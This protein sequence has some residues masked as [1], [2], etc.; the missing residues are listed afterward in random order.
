MRSLNSLLRVRAAGG[1]RAEPEG[2]AEPPKAPP[3]PVVRGKFLHVGLRKLYIKGVTYGALTPDADGREYHDQEQIERDFGLMSAA[4]INTVRIPHTMPPRSLLDA[5]QRHGLYVMVGLS[6]EQFVGYLIDTEKA[7][8]IE[9]IVRERVRRVAGHPALLCYAIGN[10]VQASVARWLGAAKIERYLKKLYLAIKEEDPGGLV[11]YVNYPSTEYLDL[12]FLDF[13]CFNVYLESR[14]ALKSYLAR[15]QNVAGD[16]PLVM[17]ELGLDSIRNGDLLQAAILRWQLRATYAA[18]CAGAFVFAWTDEWYRAGGLVNDWA[19]GITDLARR[20]KLA[21]DVVRGEFEAAPFGR[22]AG[23]PRVSVVVC[24]YNGARTIRD[25]LDALSRLEYPDYEVIVVDDGSTDSTA[26]IARGFKVE[27][28]RTANFGLSHA[29]NVGL[30]AATGEIVAYIDDDAYPDS[31][32]LSYLAASFAETPHAGIGGPNIPP[33]GGGLVADCVAR[34]PGGPTHVLLTDDVAEHITGC[35]MA[36]RKSALEAIGGFDA[37]FRVAGDDVDVCWRLQARGWTLG[38]SPAA[39]VWHHRRGSVR[40][41]W[42]QQKGYGRAEALL[43]A[44]WPEKYNAAGHPLFEGR[45]YGAAFASLFGSTGRVYHG[46]WGLAPFQRLYKSPT[47]LSALPTMPEWYLLAAALAAA[48]GL[49]LLWRPLLAA[50]PL[51]L[52]AALWSFA[53]AWRSAGAAWACAPAAGRLEALRRRGLTAFL[54]LLQP[55]ARLSGRLMAG[56]TPWRTKG[57][58]GF[59]W[60]LPRELAKFTWEWSTCEAHLEQVIRPLLEDG[61]RLVHG[62]DYADWDFELK[63]GLFGGARFLMGVEGLGAG[64]QYVRVRFRPRVFAA[65]K[66]LLLAA[67]SLA[68][69]AAVSG[70]WSACAVFCSAAALVAARALL[71]CGAAMAAIAEALPVEYEP[72]KGARELVVVMPSLEKAWSLFLNAAAAFVLRWGP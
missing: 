17:S 28:I 50:A 54:H 2:V 13:V 57:A 47:A 62:H 18:G 10:E 31:H 26:E 51:L 1:V 12:P 34:S 56:L 37:R 71:E 35:N 14:G 11:T 29:R 52:G 4:G 65:A 27:L 55:L 61:P 72:K 70:A 16:R 23:Q 33:E 20:P 25:T 43:E 44:K 40:A 36:F 22:A 6:A 39:M 42:R 7:P 60:P 15:L 24:S 49:G 5:A 38:F 46:M 30:A 45:I 8:D 68:A 19:F 41:F 53:Q 9:G 64:G 67:A 58:R 69:A 66:V 3:R 48:S 63:T 59:L 21:L 32:W